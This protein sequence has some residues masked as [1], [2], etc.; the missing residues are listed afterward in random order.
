MRRRLLSRDLLTEVR[1][2][3]GLSAAEGGARL[4]SFA[5]YLLAA[6]ALEPSEFG[7]VR[8]T[9]TLSLV[10]FIGLQVIVKALMKE[11]GASRGNREREREVLGTGIVVSLAVFVVSAALTVVAAEIGLTAPAQTG[12]LIAVLAGTACFQLYYA[13]SRGVGQVE[14][15]ATTYVGAS[16]AQFLAF[17]LLV[18]LTQPSV[19]ATLL[20][21]GATGAVPLLVWELYR[22]MLR[23]NHLR[24][25]RHAASLLWT[26]SA[27]LILGQV[28]YIVWNSADQIWVASALGTTQVGWYGAAKNLA[29]VLVV[30]PAGTNGALL[31]RMAEL[32]ASGRT[33]QA[34]TLLYRTTAALVVISS[35]IAALL[36]V[37]R[38]DLLEILYGSDYAPAAASLV[39]LSVAM[40]IYSGH[41]TLTGSAI[42]LGR[43]GISTSTICLGAAVEVIVFAFFPGSTPAF[44][45]WTYAGAIGVAFVA[46]LLL[47]LREE[48][49]LRAEGRD[50]S[51][52]EAPA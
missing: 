9:I 12:G 40:V 1:P 3:A 20:I 16:A 32:R 36:I 23:H 22:P 49:R 34:V 30:L 42:G 35:A 50:G 38:V 7:V 37:L 14:R 33:S 25:T 21:Y 45:A 2:M 27:P 44:A 26:I 8:Y 6:R 24:V 28:A 41:F 52:P 15:P 19:T 43:P 47:M 13:M 4:L 39:G 17:A 10:A 5:F 29:Q 51:Q 46:S 18:L 48:K 31:P 11:L